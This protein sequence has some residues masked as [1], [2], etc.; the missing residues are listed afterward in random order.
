MIDLII[1]AYNSEDTIARALGSVVAQTKPRKT[2]G[3]PHQSGFF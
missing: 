3:R 1:P 2:R